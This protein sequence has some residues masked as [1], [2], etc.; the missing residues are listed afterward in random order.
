[1]ATQIQVRRDTAANW[2]SADPTLAT[3]E[4]GFETDQNKFKIGDGSTAYTSLAY[5]GGSEIGN[6]LAN[7]NTITSETGQNISITADGGTMTLG[8]DNATHSTLNK[9]GSVKQITTDRVTVN[10]VK[11][12]VF[13][14][15]A[16]ASG[17][18]VTLDYNN[19]SHQVIEMNNTGDYSFND[20]TNMPDDGIMHMV[21]RRSADAIW[22][23]AGTIS[24]NVIQNN[25]G[26]LNLESLGDSSGL[27]AS[28]VDFYTGTI[29]KD[30]SANRF[31]VGLHNGYPPTSV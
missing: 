10:D 29:V 4:I 13:S 31:L 27:S 30:G 16:S 19:G 3:G 5:A 8:V 17:T 9:D 15:N 1:M 2:T 14:Y 22:G 18:S 21:I 6:T 24:A 11:Y 28:N 26:S 7:L 12:N 25:N 20:P 23:G